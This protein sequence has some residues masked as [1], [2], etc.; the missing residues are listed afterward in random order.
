MDGHFPVC[1]FWAEVRNG[2]CG[3]LV[4]DAGELQ[5][6]LRRWEVR[7]EGESWLTRYGQVGMFFG[8]WTAFPINWWL[9]TTK[10]KERMA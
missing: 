10:V 6:F 4:D 7:E 3:L 5:F 8:H 2:Q 9:I 1:D